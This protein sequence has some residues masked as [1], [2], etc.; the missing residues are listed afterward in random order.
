MDVCNFPLSLS[1][2]DGQRT[3]TMPVNSRV[4]G[5]P[6]P[7]THKYVE[8]HYACAPKV[9]ATTTKRPLPPW[10]LQSGAGDLWN[11]PILDDVQQTPDLKSS[12]SGQKSVSSTQTKTS[13]EGTS[14]LWPCFEFYS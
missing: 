11:N 13:P 8:V 7:N 6:C 9:S 1:R 3:C 14:C 4:F 2:C 12:T 10:F 5:D